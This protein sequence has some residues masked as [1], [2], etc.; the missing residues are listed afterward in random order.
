MNILFLFVDG[1]GLGADDP[2][3]NP[4]AA[5]SLP[6]FERLSGGARWIEGAPSVHDPDCLFT[7]IDA[8][9]GMDGLPQSGTGQATLFTGVNCARVAERH[10]GPFP[11]SKTRPVI[12]SKN[13]F[14]QVERLFP[15]EEAPA[16]FAN[17]YPER[18]FAYAQRRGRWTVTTL[19]AIHSK[20]R[21]RTTTD[22][23]DGMAVPADLLGR[24]WPEEVEGSIMPADELEAARRLLRLAARHR[25]TLFEYYLTDKAGHN[26]SARQ[27]R[28]VLKSLD[29]LLGALF[30]EP[31]SAGTLL[32]LTS[33]HGNMEDL[34]TKSHTRNR[35]P[36]AA[37][38]PGAGR[39]DAVRSLTDVTPALLLWLEGAEVPST[40]PRGR[41][42]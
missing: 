1:I 12:Q 6:S 21:I 14:R 36:F 34:S 10:Y 41:M 4:L 28:D 29:R 11:H 42:T 25:F 33:D 27:A 17:A 26:R 22:L 13:I 3:V 23:R 31:A 8:N 38:G 5:L 2:T 35:V 15:D 19:A 7:A 24:G 16:A 18:F 40:A 32:L 30:D 9:L 39:L 37:R 20:A